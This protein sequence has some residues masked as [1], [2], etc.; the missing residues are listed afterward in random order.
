MYNRFQV[1]YNQILPQLFPRQKHD[2]GLFPIKIRHVMQRKSWRRLNCIYGASVSNF[3]RDTEKRDCWC[4][5]GF[6]RL[7]DSSVDA[8]VST[9]ES[10]RRRNPEQ[11]YYY[12]HRHENFNSHTDYTYWIA[13]LFSSV[14]TLSRIL[15]D[16]LTPTTIGSSSLNPLLPLILLDDKL[17]IYLIQRC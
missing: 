13:S 4:S 6:W 2:L 3:D 7:G 5:S 12:H 16:S 8:K 10:T 15:I 17:S 14:P 9:D 1:V 11:H